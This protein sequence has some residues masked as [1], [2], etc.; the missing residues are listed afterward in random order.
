MKHSILFRLM[1]VCLLI[2]VTATSHAQVTKAADKINQTNATVNTTVA[3]ATQTV[4]TVKNVLGI[5]KG[6]KKEKKSDNV[7]IIITGVEYSDE[8]LLKLEN[9]FE[10]VKDV[11]SVSKTMKEGL[12]TIEVKYK[13]DANALWKTVSA[14]MQK[15]FKPMQVEEKNMLLE[16]KNNS[17]TYTPAVEAKSNLTQATVEKST[18]NNVDFLEFKIDGKLYHIDASDPLWHSMYAQLD[19]NNKT[20]RF[21]K[22]MGMKTG[23]TGG[24]SFVLAVMKINSPIEN[25]RYTIKAGDAIGTDIIL[26]FEFHNTDQTSFSINLNDKD[27]SYITDG[28][29]E[30]IH[31]DNREGG[32]SEGIFEFS[33][34]TLKSS[35]GKK[36]SSTHKL[37]D[38]KFRFTVHKLL[39]V[40]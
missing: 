32:V 16:Y 29:I 26:G 10:N 2:T 1:V 14:D 36:V 33:N 4:N 8:N 27:P 21:Y 37:T 38:G 31:F 11:K 34:I 25:S 19:D 17:G 28:C 7:L 40:Y 30:I 39:P 6:T 24:G 3:T 20:S 5:L 15:L 23:F 9:A 22:A 35:T 13:G 12:I 18:K